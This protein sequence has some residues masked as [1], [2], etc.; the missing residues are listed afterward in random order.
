MTEVER[1]EQRIVIVQAE[2]Q[3]AEKNWQRCAGALSVL[4]HM[5]G[6]AQREQDEAAK[7]PV[8]EER[9]N[10]ELP[11]QAGEHAEQD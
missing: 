5:L 6:E 11:R 1:I 7:V 10:G 2:Q 4:T 9:M 8:V 3:Q